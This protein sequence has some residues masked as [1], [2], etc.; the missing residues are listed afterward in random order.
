MAK[1]K[2][3]KKAAPRRTKR[4]RP[5]PKRSAPDWAPAFLAALAQRGTIKDACEDA[6]VGRTTVYQ[7][8][9][10]DPE[11]QA[12]LALALE[13]ATDTLDAEARKRALDGSDALLMFLLRGRRPEVYRDRQEV[14]HRGGL[15]LEIVEEIVDASD[16]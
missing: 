13:D 10:S 6:R 1:K 4:T 7:R 2:P 15:R 14:E 5:A 16:G 8:R 3:A 9:D 11:F 12:N